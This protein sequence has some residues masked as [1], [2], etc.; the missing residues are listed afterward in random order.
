MCSGFSDAVQTVQT[1]ADHNQTPLE[2]VARLNIL[3]SVLSDLQM[4]ASLGQD[5]ASSTG[6]RRRTWHHH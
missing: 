5:C 4:A 6:A 1:G 3:L 2:R